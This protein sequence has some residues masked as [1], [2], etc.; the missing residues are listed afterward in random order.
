MR[1]QVRLQTKTCKV[2]AYNFGAEFIELT[3]GSSPSALL[4]IP[5]C[6]QTAALPWVAAASDGNPGGFFQ[7][8]SFLLHSS[9]LSP[10]HRL[11]LSPKE[12]QT[13]AASPNNPVSHPTPKLFSAHPHS[14]LHGGVT[15]VNFVCRAGN[16][17]PSCGER[18][19]F[20]GLILVSLFTE[21]T[22][23]ARKCMRTSSEITVFLNIFV[24]NY[25]PN[26]HLSHKNRQT[27]YLCPHWTHP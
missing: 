5:S 10:N 23:V 20:M 8:A 26:L 13:S 4:S 6:A 2:S 18:L 21:V 9:G 22:A 16:R 12:D 1:C 19:I 27:K 15:F 24:V 14:D 11:A 7:P 17:L 3:R 25:H